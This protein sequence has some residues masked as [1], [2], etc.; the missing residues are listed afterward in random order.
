MRQCLYTSSV[1]IWGLFILLGIIAIAGLDGYLFYARFKQ[2]HLDT[3]ET[4]QT[5][6][7]Y[8][9]PSIEFTLFMIGGSV[10]SLIFIG[11]CLTSLII[12]THSCWGNQDF[13]KAS[14]Q[15][16]ASSQAGGTCGAPCACCCGML[17]FCWCGQI[18]FLIYALLCIALNVCLAPFG[19]VALILSVMVA[20]YK[21]AE[22]T[23]PSGDQKP[24]TPNEKNI[25]LQTV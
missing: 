19:F 24:E 16:S 25:E 23:A 8:L 6:K 2:T 14:S 22:P 9:W 13:L 7:D 15:K 17:I 10:I 11:I 21:E 5:N 3:L 4:N 20:S 1:C 12:A 18:G